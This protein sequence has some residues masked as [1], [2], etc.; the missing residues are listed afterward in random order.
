MARNES[1]A[2]RIA[3]RRANAVDPEAFLRELTVVEPTEDGENL[4]FT[5][6]FVSRVDRQLEKVR[7]AGVET[8]DI[9]DMFG[10]TEANVTVA[11]RPYTAYKTRT[12][13]RNWPSEAALELDV[14]VDRELRSET[15]RWDEVPPRQ[16]HRLLQ[17]LRSFRDDCPFC[18]GPVAIGDETV[19]SCCGDTEVVTVGCGECDR[20]FLEFSADSIPGR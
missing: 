17:S 1:A 5:P 2:D 13:V 20:R 4:Q 11:D 8:A 3:Y 12:T 19:E 15:D 18:G 9:A 16:R 6:A 14:A 10:V 7:S